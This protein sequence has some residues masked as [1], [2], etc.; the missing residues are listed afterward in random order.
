M[1]SLKHYFLSLLSLTGLNLVN[2]TLNNEHKLRNDLFQNYSADCLPLGHQESITLKMGVAFRA[3]NS[4]DQVEG[5]LT[6]NIWLRHWW[7]DGN[8]IW[9]P[10]DYNNITEMA[11][12]TEPGG[13]SSIWVPDI[14][15]Y[16]T[17][18]K[19]MEQLDYS[20]AHV[21][22]DGY[23]I[24]SRPGIIKST[25]IFDLR[26]FPYDT[27]HC[28]FKFG[29]WVYHDGQMN[30]TL[31]EGSVDVSNFQEND[32]WNL[33]NF[34]SKLNFVKYNC[35]PE[36]YPDITFNITLER[37][38]G[39]YTL[40]IITPAYATSSLMIISFLVPWDSGERISFAITV[41]L[42]L[43]VFLLILSENLPKT[44]T[45]PLLSEMLI[46]LTF[47]SLLCVFFTVF[48]S[49]MYSY[50]SK[51]ENLIFKVIKKISYYLPNLP[52]MKNLPNL[53]NMSG[54]GSCLPGSNRD[55]SQDTVTHMTITESEVDVDDFIYATEELSGIEHRTNSYQEVMVDGNSKKVRRNESNLSTL[56][57]RSITSSDSNAS[58]ASNG[59]NA[60]KQSNNSE[61][62]NSSKGSDD[63]NDS[64]DSDATTASEKKVKIYARKLESIFTVIFLVSFIIY[65]IIMF[66]FIPI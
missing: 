63:S 29:S 32:G 39:Y 64:N 4:I 52:E 20:R 10:D 55:G 21:Y 16:N 35:C 33:A 8:L 53:P 62:S 44:N 41:M 43:I 40:N 12:N 2:G 36:L 27:Q 54:F 11:V 15:L 66:A 42:S 26:S 37:L 23:I 17:A 9:N 48:V 25:C 5:T 58:N 65:T 31:D 60:T 59:S 19:P 57:Q 1:F 47:F 14:Y 56:T 50:K 6:A 22:S 45:K 18:E 51:K 24:W 7:R 61:D 13:D 28:L 38:P 34:S 46:G 49:A 3:F 30:L